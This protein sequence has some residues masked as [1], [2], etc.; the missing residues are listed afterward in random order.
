MEVPRIETSWE[1]TPVENFNYYFNPYPEPTLLSKVYI[2]NNGL[3]SPLKFI[4]PTHY[5]I[6]LCPSVTLIRR[7]KLIIVRLNLN[8]AEVSS[9]DFCGDDGISNSR[10]MAYNK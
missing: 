10:V 6:Y 7:T 2:I 4:L 8:S 5:L 1:N 3:N 9:H